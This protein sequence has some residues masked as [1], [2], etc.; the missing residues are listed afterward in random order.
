MKASL[1]LFLIVLGGCQRQERSD[2]SL[3]VFAAAS[4]SDA[5]KALAT[6]YRDAGGGALRFNFASSG[7]LARQIDAGAP[8]DLFVSANVKWMDWLAER[9]CI[10]TSTRFDLAGN[11][12]VLIAPS[13][14]PLPFNE[15]IPGHLAVGDFNSVPVG[16]YAKEALERMGWL[17]ALKPK[18]VMGSSARTV[19]LYVERGEVAAGVVYAS[20]AKASGQV[21]IAGVFPGSLHSPIVY[22]AAACHGKEEAQ[23]FLRFLKTGAAKAILTEHGFAELAD[24]P[25]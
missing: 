21:R 17:E 12:L 4:T 10:D 23:H 8:V 11:R 25:N 18:L 13:D 16:M 7:A 20:D 2:S 1:F 24:P 19:L 9:G 6:A 22:P 14:K 15:N 5:M 3:T